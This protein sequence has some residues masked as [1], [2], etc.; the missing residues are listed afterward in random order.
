MNKDIEILS[1]N[2]IDVSNW[3]PERFHIQ[4]QRQQ[5]RSQTNGSQ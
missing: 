5:F 3:L 1:T 4:S 2:I